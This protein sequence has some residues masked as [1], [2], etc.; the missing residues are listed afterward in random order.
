MSADYRQNADR[1]IVQRV[2]ALSAYQQA[3]TCFLYLSFLGEVD[4][5]TLLQYTLGQKRV[6]VP[7]CITKGLME[8]YE[9]QDFSDLEK[10]A[11]GIDEPKAY[12]KKVQAVEIDFAVIP[13][14]SCTLR[15][16]RLG[17]GGGYYDRYLQKTVFPS[18]VLCYDELISKNIPTDVWDKRIDRVITEK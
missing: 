16:E 8:A 2:L 5:W 6:V 1:N 17:Y 4:T 18:V 12:C 13:C 10:G 15:G 11:Y 3:K 7:K 14:V 9:I